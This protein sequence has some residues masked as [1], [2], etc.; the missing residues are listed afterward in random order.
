MFER[1]NHVDG[2]R[3]EEEILFSTGFDY[4]FPEAARSRLCLVPDSEE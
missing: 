2:I 1:I 3:T 4:L